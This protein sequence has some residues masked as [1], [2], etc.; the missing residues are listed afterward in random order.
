MADTTAYEHERLGQDM[1]SRTGYRL[2]RDDDASTLPPG[3]DVSDGVSRDE[4]V[5]IALWNNRDFAVTLGELG[6]GRARLADSGLLT[7]PILSL[8]FPLGPKQLE[9]TIGIPFESLFLRSQRIDM[10]R[11][12]CERLASLLQRHGL[13]LIRDV[14]LAYIDHDLAERRAELATDALGL[15]NE[16]AEAARLRVEAGE[17]SRVLYDTALADAERARC[18]V[19][20]RTSA[21]RELGE[22]LMTWMAWRPPNASIPLH[23]ARQPTIPTIPE[24]PDL[25]TRALAARPDLRAAEFAAEAASRAAGLAHRDWLTVSALIDANGSGSQGFEIGPGFTAAIP[26]FR[27]GT[28]AIRDAEFKLALTRYASI[29]QSIEADVS[30]FSLGC[31]QARQ[32]LERLSTKL[33]P[34]VVARFEGLRLQIA[35]G[36]EA[37]DATLPARGELLQVDIDLAEADANLR[38][39]IVRLEHACG[40]SLGAQRQADAVERALATEGDS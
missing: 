1:F 13:D 38:R 18:E 39:A 19:L 10:A 30:L 32:L 6:V 2:R 34:A 21:A 36:Q 5:A 27:Q 7:N 26:I 24:T 11:A 8:L 14:S 17:T 3:I 33:R 22:R 29:R 40:S 35:A 16:R 15:A 23:T 9:F 28:A 25:L 31:D 20:R 12:D 37:E 4:A